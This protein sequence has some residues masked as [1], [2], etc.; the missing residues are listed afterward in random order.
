MAFNSLL[1]RM[2]LVGR[3]MSTR[4]FASSSLASCTTTTT[5]CSSRLLA[6]RALGAAARSSSVAR[7]QCRLYSEQSEV[8]AIQKKLDHPPPPLDG[9]D[10]VPQHI[11]DLVDQVLRVCWCLMV[12]VVDAIAPI[13]HIAIQTPTTTPTTTT[14]TTTTATAFCSVVIRVVVQ[15]D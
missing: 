13:Q 11:K 10:A 5:A 8:E 15:H 14:T 6:R 1:R 7:V 12:D 3:V 2:T 4:G 9:E